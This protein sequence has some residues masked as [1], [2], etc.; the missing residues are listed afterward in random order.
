MAKRKIS[1]ALG[2]FQRLFGDEQALETAAKIGADAV[3]FNLTGYWQG[4]GGPQALYNRSDEEITAYFEN[5]YRRAAALG[6]EIGQT[7]GRMDTYYGDPE[8]DRQVIASARL[9]CL[10]T[11]ALHARYCVMHSVSSSVV[12]PDTD[13]QRIRDLCF[14][15]FN[16]IL[17]FAKAYDVTIATETFGYCAARDCCDFFGNAEEFFAIYQRICREGDADGHFAICVDTGH[18]NHAARFGNPPP[19]EIIR[20]AG[21][22]LVCLHMHDNDGRTDQHKIPKTGTIDW[23]AVFDALDAVGYRGIYNM[24]LHLGQLGRGFE[25]EMAA[26]AIKLMRHMLQE[27][28]GQE[29]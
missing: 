22:H 10:A 20:R 18:S 23:N 8:K 13:P 9:D 16:Q 24:E 15:V 11:R 14:S 26:F 27:R 5:L 3:D 12:P 2:D 6:L 19:Q 29:G 28:Y 17:P 7:H 25:V 1:I 4:R 21:E